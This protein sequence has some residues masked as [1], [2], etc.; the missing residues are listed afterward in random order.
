MLDTKS[1]EHCTTFGQLLGEESSYDLEVLGW[2]WST[3]V[4]F[5][6]QT[7]QITN[8]RKISQFVPY[9]RTVNQ[10]HAHKNLKGLHKHVEERLYWQM[11]KQQQNAST[12]YRAVKTIHLFREMR[13]SLY[14]ARLP[15]LSSNSKYKSLK[16]MSD[17]YP[18]SVE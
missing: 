2:N 15:G 11:E 3:I 14:V 18:T 8:K 1:T 17:G 10:S 16:S 4:T 12:K 5:R 6:L 9:S 13:I 7:P